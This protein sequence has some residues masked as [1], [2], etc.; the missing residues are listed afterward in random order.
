M[1]V[2]GMQVTEFCIYKEV[3][4]KLETKLSKNLVAPGIEPEPPDL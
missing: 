1:V 4:L 3:M 2:M